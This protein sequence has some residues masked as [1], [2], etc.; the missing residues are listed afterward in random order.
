[1]MK[2]THLDIDD[3]RS[4]IAHFFDVS[5]EKVMIDCYMETVGYGMNEHK[6]PTVRAVVTT[7]NDN[8]Q[9]GELNGL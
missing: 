2:M 8:K 5:E 4:I 1:M 9:K 6:E 3:I 7:Y